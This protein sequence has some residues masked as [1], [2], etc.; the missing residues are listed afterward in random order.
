MTNLPTVSAGEHQNYGVMLP[1]TEENF[2]EFISDILSTKQRI[3]TRV[4]GRYIITKDE[5]SNIYNVL[6]QRVSMQNKGSLVSFNI[7]VSY[8]DTTSISLNSLEEF[9]QYA[10][11]KP[12]SAVSM[13]LSWVFLINFPGR[14]VPGK[15]SVTVDFMKH[16]GDLFFLRTGFPFFPGRVERANIFPFTISIEHSNRTWGVDIE[17]LLQNHIKTLSIKSPGWQMFLD[18]V[19]GLIGAGLAVVLS[20]FLWMF[21][22]KVHVFYYDM[23]HSEITN[24]IRGVKSD[25]L[26]DISI[27]IIEIM[28]IGEFKVALLA[29]IL[30]YISSLYL[31]ALVGYYLSGWL[32]YSRKSFIAFS[33]SENLQAINSL[34][35]EKKIIGFCFS[36]I[37]ISLFISVFANYIFQY[38]TR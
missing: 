31:S 1:C 32:K 36:A 15:E 2:A 3:R 4:S 25:D 14:N 27:K 5:V 12:H 21:L 17:S 19:S 35:H 6:M 7:N 16:G 23:K 9:I 37:F 34:N 10:E 8:D 28:N 29:F 30:M 18:K 38:L 11:V 13:S 33:K 22:N 20:F 26:K 24:A